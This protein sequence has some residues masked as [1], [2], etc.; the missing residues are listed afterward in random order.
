MRQTLYFLIAS[1]IVIC[2]GCSTKKS[3]DLKYV[4][5]YVG[6]YTLNSQTFPM[7]F[8]VQEGNGKAIVFSYNIGNGFLTGKYGDGEGAP[9]I[10]AGK[11]SQGQACFWGSFSETTEFIGKIQFSTEGPVGDVRV[12]RQ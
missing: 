5:V 11:L 9:R 3:D 2:G 4:G 8:T 12:K 6:T 10:Q 1:I 7:T